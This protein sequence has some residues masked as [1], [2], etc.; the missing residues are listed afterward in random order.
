[1]KRNKLGCIIGIG[2]VALIVFGFFALLRG[3]LSGYDER[4]KIG[5]AL[6]FDQGGKSVVF[7]LVQYDQCTSYSR[8][9]GFVNKSVSTTYYLQ[10]NDPATGKV[11]KEQELIAHSDLKHYPV[12][13]LG[14]AGTTAW[15][16]ADQLQGYN[17]FTLAK[18]A[19]V[20]TLEQKNPSL[21]GMFPDERQ[22]YHFQPDGKIKFTAKNGIEE[23][24][25]LQSLVIKPYDENDDPQK[26]KS[27]AIKLRQEK[28]NRDV[29]TLYQ[30]WRRT[31]MNGYGPKS[32]TAYNRWQR[33]NDL[34]RRTGD[35]VND[36]DQIMSD[37]NS[38]MHDLQDLMERSINVSNIQRMGDT[39]NG[40][41]Y[42]LLNDEELKRMDGG[43]FYN[44]SPS[45]DAARRKL[46][47]AK[48]L[49]FENRVFSTIKIDAPQTAATP[50]IYIQGGL[51]VDR[52]S[53]NVMRLTN[54]GG[55]LVLAR[56]QI[57]SKGSFILTRIG[58]DGKQYWSVTLPV[59]ELQ[60]V[61]MSGN[62]LVFFARDNSEISSD[63]AN[64]LIS[65]DL[66]NGKTVLYDYMKN[67]LRDAAA[68]K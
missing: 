57:G 66:S 58:F 18:T 46:Y 13:V 23:L 53:N 25:D 29:D 60:D 17:A 37:L 32:D 49:Q 45:G 7:T 14:S 5:R 9:G 64:L 4:S 8:S 21:K 47:T 36:I 1:M 55:Y 12:E 44:G 52:Q 24:L 20:A 26:K 68:A 41:V 54:P 11:I 10:T 30:Q 19:D 62:R 2:G 35:S 42:M 50:G 61:A 3:C 67:A 39:L 65:L 22:Y 38:R 27:A 48:M 51:L 34:A 31:T 43:Y 28:L 59:S 6:L 33:A 56:D 63:Q 16:F 15:I 40:R